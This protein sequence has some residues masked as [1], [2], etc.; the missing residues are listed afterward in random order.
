MNFSLGKSN[1]IPWLAVALGPF[2]GFSVFCKLNWK[3]LYFQTFCGKY[4]LPDHLRWDA[5]AVPLCK[6]I[7]V[8]LK[9]SLFIRT[10]TEVYLNTGTLVF[11]FFNIDWSKEKSLNTIGSAHTQIKC[12]TWLM[13]QLE[14]IPVLIYQHNFVLKSFY[15]G[16][17]SMHEHHKIYSRLMLN[18]NKM[19]P[20]HFSFKVIHFL[21]SN[22]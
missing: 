8:T 5:C 18:W 16:I 15:W 3:E 7:L 13:N 1:L 9:H 22:N 20:R 10:T 14:L 12:F 11:L 21:Q 6:A 4:S 19:P 17:W 2:Q